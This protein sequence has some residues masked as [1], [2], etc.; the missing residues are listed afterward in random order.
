MRPSPA[1][2]SSH[3]ATFLGY[4]LILWAVIALG[5]GVAWLLGRRLG[6]TQ[7]GQFSEAVTF[8]GISFAFLLGLLQVFVTNHYRD[9]RT[10]AA[11]EA[12]TLIEMYDELGVFPQ[13]VRQQ[14]QHDVVCYMRSIV[15]RD[16]KKQE[17]GITEQTPETLILG[18]RIRSLRRTLPVRGSPIR[19]AAYARFAEDVS[20][21][22]R[23]RQQLLILARPQVPTV[24][25]ILVFVS[26]GLVAF[27]VLSEFRPRPKLI[28]IA[29]LVA[30]IVLLTFET[31][32][33][34]SL[35][36]PFG[37]VAR[38]GPDSLSS[39]LGLLSAGRAGN[40]VFGPCTP[41]AALR[42]L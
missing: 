10:Q 34:V 2:G 19:Q 39:G 41:P 11:T 26:A 33:L 12:T 1:V 21:A 28:R 25:W 16:W 18:D 35:D 42:N 36:R 14:A 23:A 8:I 5:F 30:L 31:G 40:P 24:L 32:S 6:E 38:V 29:V 37:P 17:Q 22:G 7:A 4:L 27:L 20:V 9:A 15:D 3:L 13:Q